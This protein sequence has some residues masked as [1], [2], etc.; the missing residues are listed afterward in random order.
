MGQSEC[1]GMEGEVGLRG[2]SERP[3]NKNTEIS[4]AGAFPK[5]SVVIWSTLDALWTLIRSFWSTGT[6]LDSVR[7]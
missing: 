1:E 3:H 4:S 6:I 2:I 7:H 5:P